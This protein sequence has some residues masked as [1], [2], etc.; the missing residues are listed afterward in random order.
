MLKRHARMVESGLRILDLATLVGA[1]WVAN[2]VVA[3]LGRAPMSLSILETHFPL[4]ATV[5]LGWLGAS[6][7]V[8]LYTA[9]RMLPVL[10]EVLRL[11]QALAFAAFAAAMAAPLWNEG[12]LAPAV[13]Q[14]YPAVAF[15]LMVTGRLVIRSAAGLARR[16]GFNTRRVAVV[17][18]GH[19]A[20]EVVERF[21]NHPEWGY[22]FAGYVLEDG[23]EAE[24][25]SLV[26]CRLSQ[27]GDLLQDAV[28]DEVVFA[29]PT[30]R[31][32]AV[33]EAARL[34]EQQG[35][36]VRLFV[37]FL[38]GGLARL[39][40]SGVDGLPML[41]YSSVPTNELALA[42]KRAF[43][44]AVSATVLL[45]LSPVLLGI[46]IA[47]RRESP[48]PILFR[49]RRVGLNGREFDLFKFRSMHLDAEAQLAKL[50]AL[51]EASG[52][53]FKMR[54]DPR[55]TRIG[56]FIRKT[57]FDEF[58]QF[59][60]VLRGEMSVVGPRPPLPSEV[61]QYERWQRRRLSVRPGIT[62]TW[63]ISGRSDI[64][65]ERWMRLDLEYIDNWS[66]LGDLQIFART[67]PAVLSARGA[68]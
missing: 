3:V 27:F 8:R 29:V 23:V 48:G 45:L 34:C 9:Y 35:I 43:D 5:L 47:I 14:F 55:V 58:P 11:F 32:V 7:V 49:Q 12:D 40:S 24:E 21:A 51:N 20:A 57:S 37:D 16:S 52:P 60:N 68:R 41:A 65:F 50:T 44:I 33:Q 22:N 15:F 18:Q 10:A 25:G 46:A 4:L 61:R 2:F 56:R 19:L 54:N 42:A 26:L 66:L 62:C 36:S 30:D 13:L 38:H 59:W 17:G 1:L 6:A 63:Q 64:S 53:V 28:L 31:L 67:I 39:E